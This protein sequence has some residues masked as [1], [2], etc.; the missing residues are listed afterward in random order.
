M[1]E[2]E[3]TTPAAAVS[4]HALLVGID[5]YR[6]HDVPQLSGCA[7]DIRAVQDFLERR[8]AQEGFAM[9]VPKVLINAEAT[10]AR[11]I[12]GLEGLAKSVGAQDIVVLYY[13]GHGS[14]EAC[15]PEF[16]TLEPD[17][18]NEQFGF[19]STSLSPTNSI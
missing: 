6:A 1:P 10:R 15:P 12:E 19:C 3:P 9:T 18:F 14:Q 13:S 16:L 11:V 7:N 8:V 2:T 4:V 5:E 17:G